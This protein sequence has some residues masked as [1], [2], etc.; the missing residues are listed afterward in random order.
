MKGFRNSPISHHTG[1]QLMIFPLHA[2]ESTKKTRQVSAVQI[3]NMH[4]PT[5]HDSKCHHRGISERTSPIA[6]KTVNAVLD[7][8][9][10]WRGV[11]PETAR[12]KEYEAFKLVW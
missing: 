11:F 4:V 7:A 8:V 12:M 9:I 6:E 2:M 3:M 5:F 1:V 10:P